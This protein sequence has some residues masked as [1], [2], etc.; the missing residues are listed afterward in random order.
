MAR[1]ATAKGNLKSS[2]PSPPISSC[3]LD[4]L[5]RVCGFSLGHEEATRLANISLI[6]AKEE[7]M[8]AL[9]NTRHKLTLSS[10]NTSETETRA[11]AFPESSDAQNLHELEMEENR[12]ITDDNLLPVDQG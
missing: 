6:Q 9:L 2:A 3:S 11:T 10:A 7:V 12:A 5:A 1:K 4:D 8:I